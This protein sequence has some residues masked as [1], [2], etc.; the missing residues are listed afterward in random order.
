MFEQEEKGERKKL[1]SGQPEVSERFRQI[2]ART[3]RRDT[4]DV[5]VTARLDTDLGA[6]SLDLIEITMEVESEFNIWL[7]EKNIL[8]TAKETFGEGVLE[9]EGV[10]TD[11]GRRLLEHRLS[12]E[13]FA[14][15]PATIRT[16]DLTPF[17]MTV[18]A[19]IRLIEGLVAQKPSKCSSCGSVN[20][21][22]GNGFRFQCKDCGV[23]TVM[24]SGDDINR[25]WVSS[26]FETEH[27]AASRLE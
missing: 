11:K 22:P 16:A 26:Y 1:N 23:F 14:R 17:F 24:P 13:D 7:P 12:P 19:W 6:E 18:G 2:V 27:L 4:S 20:L 10:L 15:L 5:I 9:R 3:L 8:E 21:I 25:A